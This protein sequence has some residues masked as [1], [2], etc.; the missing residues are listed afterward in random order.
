[1]WCILALVQTYSSKRLSV[2][3]SVL[4]WQPLH[5]DGQFSLISNFT[6]FVTAFAVLWFHCCFVLPFYRSLSLMFCVLWTLQHAWTKW[7]HLVT[8]C[9]NVYEPSIV[10]HRRYV[11]DLPTYLLDCVCYLN[12]LSFLLYTFDLTRLVRTIGNDYPESCG[13]RLLYWIWTNWSCI[14]QK[15]CGLWNSCSIAW[16]GDLVV[17]AL[18]LRST[19]RGFDSRPPYCQK[20]TEASRSD[21]SAYSASEVTVL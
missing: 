21:T 20:A 8:W 1:M 17:R 15:K 3:L 6:V 4:C 12:H 16:L 7:I 11:N 9:V 14:R 5:S 13:K 2:R 10:R 19:G 18:D